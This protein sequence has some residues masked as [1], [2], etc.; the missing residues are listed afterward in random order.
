MI[1][2]TVESCRVMSIFLLLPFDKYH[3]NIVSKFMCFVPNALHC[4]HSTALSVIVL[5][6][7]N[8]GC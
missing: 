1:K 3:A 6:T 8:N 7:A 4:I 2:L 5:Y